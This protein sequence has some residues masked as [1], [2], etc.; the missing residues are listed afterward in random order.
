MELTEILLGFILFAIV[1]FG[2]HFDGE[3]DKIREEIRNQSMR[4]VPM[5]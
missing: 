3:L 5:E 4:N 2:A 1:I